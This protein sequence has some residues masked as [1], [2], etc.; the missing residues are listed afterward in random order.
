MTVNRMTVNSMFFFLVLPGAGSLPRPCRLGGFPSSGRGG[1]QDPLVVLLRRIRTYWWL[2][3]VDVLCMQNMISM[4]WQ[5]WTMVK[6]RC[7]MDTCTVHLQTHICIFMDQKVIKS[8]GYILGI[9]SN[10]Y[11]SLPRKYYTLIWGSWQVSLRF[12]IRSTALLQ[13]PYRDVPGWQ[14]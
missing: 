8:I 10:Y 12:V 1:F 9:I 6:S 5:L 11:G 3:Y 4:T 14:K 2:N 7:K 13:P